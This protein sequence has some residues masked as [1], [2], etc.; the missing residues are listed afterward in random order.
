MDI[1]NICNSYFT[2]IGTNINES[3]NIITLKTKYNRIPNNDNM[4]NNNNAIL[5]TNNIS[6]KK[7]K[8][9]NN[10][11]LNPITNVADFIIK[12]HYNFN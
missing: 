6:S 10:I 3:F 9:I 1:K 4:L 7:S 5:N 2:T 11:D 12:P 8:D